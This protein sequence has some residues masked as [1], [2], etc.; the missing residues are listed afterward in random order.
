MLKWIILLFGLTCMAIAMSHIA[1]GPSVIP[2]A[3]P[4]NPTMDSEDRFYATLFLGFGA[5]LA[6]CSRNLQKRGGVFGA[7]MIVFFLGGIARLISAVQ[8]GLPNEFFQVLWALELILP[9]VLWTWWRR[10]YG[11][12]FVRSSAGYG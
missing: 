2:G 10:S 8:V 6:W 7:L 12:D 1:L 11:S 3:I 4:V 9:P 5:A